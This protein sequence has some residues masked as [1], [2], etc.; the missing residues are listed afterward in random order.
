[1]LYGGLNKYSVWLL[2]SFI[3]ACKIINSSKTKKM[4]VLIDKNGNVIDEAIH[5]SAINSLVDQN[6]LQFNSD[7][8]GFKLTNKGFDIGYRRLVN[9]GIGLSTVEIAQNL[10][11]TKTELVVSNVSS[12]SGNQ[13]LDP[14]THEFSGNYLG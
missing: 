9:A 7:K 8:T 12:I 4:Y 13:E 5:P 14:N 10:K 6:L 3:M 11:A 1:M 2:S